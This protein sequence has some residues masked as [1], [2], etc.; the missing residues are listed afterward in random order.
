[1]DRGDDPPQDQDSGPTLLP[2][3]SIL[4]VIR[5][6]CY[7]VRRYGGPAD[8][9]T[10]TSFALSFAIRAASPG[11]G[12]LGRPDRDTDS[13]VR[14][15]CPALVSGSAETDSACAEVTSPA[16]ANATPMDS[17]PMDAMT[18]EQRIMAFPIPCGESRFLDHIWSAL[19]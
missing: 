16:T 1:M 9:L 18:L 15:L 12:G 3:L 14:L 6:E 11:C 8:S 10:G 7:S 17:T 5:H 19:M 2:I 13:D 4:G